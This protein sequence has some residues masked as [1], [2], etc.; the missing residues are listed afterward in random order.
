MFELTPKQHKV[1]SLLQAKVFVS[2]L[3]LA[4]ALGLTPR[5]MRDICKKWVKEGFLA[6]ADPS[7]KARMYKLGT[8]EQKA[9]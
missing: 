2:T 8:G 6:V 4:N 5:T 7:N 1:L 3:D 9:E